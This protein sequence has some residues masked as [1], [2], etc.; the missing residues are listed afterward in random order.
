[1]LETMGVGAFR[2]HL[3]VNLLLD[4]IAEVRRCSGYQHD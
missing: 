1:M 2:L 3:H 4:A